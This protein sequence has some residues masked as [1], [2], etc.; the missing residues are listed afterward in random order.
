MMHSSSGSRSFPW[1]QYIHLPTGSQFSSRPPGKYQITLEHLD[2]NAL[3]WIV[4]PRILKDCSGASLQRFQKCSV[5]LR[6]LQGIVYIPIATEMWLNIVCIGFWNTIHCTL[7]S[8]TLSKSVELNVPISHGSK[9][10][11]N[12]QAIQYLFTAMWRLNNLYDGS[13]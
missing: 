8:Y 6:S 10:P 4:T 3:D 2:A 13:F 11:N 1:N 9:I 7:I 5:E 12:W